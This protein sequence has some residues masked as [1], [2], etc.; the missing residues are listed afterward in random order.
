MDRANIGI[1]VTL[2]P[3]GMGAN[4]MQVT[5]LATDR[6]PVMVIRDR[7]RVAIVNSNDEK[8]VQFTLLPFLQKVGVNQIHLAIALNA[9]APMN[10]W[11]TLVEKFRSKR[12][13]HPL[14]CRRRH[15]LTTRHP[16]YCRSIKECNWARSRYG[17][18]KQNP[19]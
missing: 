7:G 11:Q 5:V 10:G 1:V 3:L 18:F 15:P 4:L 19:I 6:D 14:T 12:W 13:W 2:I 9:N 17:Y 8:T 16:K